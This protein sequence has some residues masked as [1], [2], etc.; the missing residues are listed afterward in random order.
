VA[1]LLGTS[2]DRASPQDTA[3]AC[4][5][6]LRLDHRIGDRWATS[7]AFG[8]GLVQLTCDPPGSIVLAV[9]PAPDG[10][11]VVRAVQSAT[12]PDAVHELDAVLARAF[13]LLDGI[14]APSGVAAQGPERDPWQNA[15]AWLLDVQ[16]A[17]R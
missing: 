17:G 6:G 16:E 7:C 13:T 12:E 4:D 14:A 2:R 11:A 3:I 1:Y 8:P 10:R 9:T 5:P 15:R